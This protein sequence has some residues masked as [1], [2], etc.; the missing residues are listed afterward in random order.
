[1]DDP[2]L[3]PQTRKKYLKVLYKLCGHHALLPSATHITVSYDRDG[4]VLYRGG[5]VS[6]RRDLLK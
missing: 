6:G 2:N 3:L 4:S 1:M 5:F